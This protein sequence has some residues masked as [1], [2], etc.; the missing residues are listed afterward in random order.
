MRT[1]MWEITTCE[2]YHAG[3]SENSYGIGP[4]QLLAPFLRDGWEPYAVTERAYRTSEFD[5]LRYKVTHYLRRKTPIPP[6]LAPGKIPPF[7]P[8]KR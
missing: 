1:W 3:Y 7:A 6:S 2:T 5:P 4:A 8:G